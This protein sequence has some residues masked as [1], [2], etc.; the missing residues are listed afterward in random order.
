[1]NFPKVQNTQAM[2]S[3][4]HSYAKLEDDS[5]LMAIAE[6]Q[7]RKAF[8]EIYRRYQKNAFNLAR[9]LTGNLEKAD[10]AVQE[11]MLRVWSKA[12]NFQKGGNARGWILRIIARISLR[13]GSSNRTKEAEE[14]RD[15][16][17]FE[18]KGTVSNGGS[19]KAEMEEQ[20]TVLRGG[21]DRLSPASRRIV[22]LYYGVGLSQG[23]I[24]EELS[25][26]QRTVSTQLKDA[27]ERL[28]IHLAQQGIAAASLLLVREKLEEALG[29]GP[30]PSP[31]IA[32]KLQERLNDFIEQTG[33]THSQPQIPPT[34]SIGTGLGWGWA[35]LFAFL[36]MGAGFVWY[37]QSPQPSKNSSP[38]PL[39][40]RTGSSVQ[41]PVEPSASIRT[42][43]RPGLGVF[44]H[45]ILDKSAPI[46]FVTI[47]GNSRWV[48]PE[49]GQP[50]RL[51]VTSLT[52]VFLPLDMS[53]DVPVRITVRL[54]MI[55][56]E[57]NIEFG[58]A[59]TWIGKGQ[60]FEDRRIT[61]QG[62]TQ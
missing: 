10:E 31:E 1:M 11:G 29:D 50:G 27:L 51:R 20:L 23:E 13:I 18:E 8:A 59:T 38:L 16:D 30:M 26:S 35:G 37:S 49:K 54:M 21:L 2:N 53:A 22:A 56:F 45:W 46:E 6:T 52:R 5:L 61:L 3:A 14:F 17:R 24:G 34:K 39:P 58:F 43:R 7:D 55:P 40:P 41:K 25:V 57:N 62:N 48:P 32:D 4:V 12:G 15:M 19:V 36:A 28:R 9:H 42:E 60:N 33:P 44:G 47:A